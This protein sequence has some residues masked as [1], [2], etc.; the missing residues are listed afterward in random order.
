MGTAAG[1]MPRE[2]KSVRPRRAPADRSVL[3]KLEVL[4]DGEDIIVT[5][6]YDYFQ[7]CMIIK[8]LV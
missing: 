8:A 5:L 2:L 3:K 1:L 4:N 6:Q 7:K